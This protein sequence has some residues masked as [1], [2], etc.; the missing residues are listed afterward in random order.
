MNR[1]LCT[2]LILITF[3]PYSASQVATGVA[4]FNS[5]GGG[6]F[7]A[8]NLGNLNVHFSI[9]V[10]HKAGR[11]TPFAYD[12]NYD[13]STYRPVVSNGTTQWQPV[14]SIGNIASYWGWQ[15]LG[16]VFSPYVTY[17]M[18]F[19]SGMCG[20]FGNQPW[21]EYSYSNFTY[22]DAGG[23]PHPFNAGGVYYNSPG[24]PN[25]P[26][27]GAQPP[28]TVTV[29]AQDGSG[30]LMSYSLG[31]GSASGSIQS[32]D[33]TTISAPWLTSPPTGSS[34]YAGTD[35]NGNKISFSNGTYTD[36]LGQAVLVATGAAPNP[37]NFSYIPP[38]NE[39]S[40]TRVSVT[41]N[42][43]NYT[44]KTNFGALDSGGHAIGEYSSSTAVALVDNVT[45][46]DG[47]QYKFQYEPTPATPSIGACTPLPGTTCTTGRILQITLPTGGAITYAYSG[48]AN[49]IISDGSTAGLTRTL[50][51]PGGQWSY[52]RSQVAGNH[53]QNTVTSPTGDNTV[54]DFMEDSATGNGST[55]SFYETKRQVNQLISGVQTLLLTTL[56]CWN[57]N[58][59][60]TT[61]STVSS[62]ITQRQVTLQ[63][64]SGGLQSKT[65]TNYNGSGLVTENDEY[66]YSSGA[67]TTLARKTLISYASL[68]NNIVD[69]PSSVIVYDGGSH[70]LSQTAY[71]YD[72]YTTYPLQSTT[73]TPQHNSI[74]G[75]RGN[76]TTLAST[77]IGATTLTRHFAYYDTG[78]VY[79]DYDV[80]G[81]ITTYNYDATV[82]GNSTRSCGNSFPTSVTL[83]ISG[84]SSLAS[85]TYDCIGGVSTAGTD[86]NGNSRSTS[87]TDTFFWRPASATAPYT[88]TGTTTKNFTYTAYNATNGNLAKV[89]SKMLFNSNN[90][91]VD[92][93]TT[94]SL[95]GQLLYSQ[96]GE[97]PSSANYDST[98][99]LYDSFLRAYKSSMPCVYTSTIFTAQNQACPSAATTTST[100]DGLGRVTQTQDGG[101]GYVTSTYNQNDVKQALGPAPAGENLKQKQLEYDALSRLTS[102]CEI[103]QLASP[104]TCGQIGNYTG[105]LTTYAYGVN[106][107]NYPTMTVTQGPSGSQQTRVYT[108]DLLGR[109]ISEQNPE[110]GTTTYTYDSDSSGVCSGTYTGDLVKLVDAKGNKVCYQYDAIHRKTGITYPSSGPDAS[111]TQSKTFVYDAAAFNGT[112][113]AN[114]KGLMVEAYTGASGSKT[115]DEF[116]SYSVRGELLDTWECTP[117]SG[118][119]G[120]AAPTN[121]YHVNAGFWENGAWKSLSSSFSGLPT[122]TYGIDSMGRSNTVS[123]S[124]GQNPVTSTAYDLA[125][126]KTTVTYG[127]ADSDVVTFD[128]NTGRM[129]QYKFNVASQNVTGNFTWNPNGSLATLAITNQLNSL[130]TQTCAY[131]HDDV[132]R[133]SSVGCLN[134]STHRWD[135]TFTYDAFGNITKTVPNGGTGLSFQPTYQSSTNRITALSGCT[136][137]TDANGQ[138]TY[139]CTHN[140]T[141]DAEHKLHSADANPSNC[142][143]GGECLTYDALGRMVEKAVGSTYTQ[144]VYGPQG[145][146]ATMNGQTL[147]G[148]LIPVPG[149]QVMYTSASLNTTN[150]I[151]YYR[152]AD[153]LGSSRLAATPS[154]TLY[155][156]TAYAPFGEAYSQSGTTDLSFTGQ[157]QDTVSGIYDFSARNDPVNQGRW[158]VPDP[159]GFAAADPAIPQSWNRYA[160]VINNPLVL[161]DPTG[162]DYCGGSSAPYTTGGGGTG[163]LPQP[164]CLIATGVYDASWVDPNYSEGATPGSPGYF[165]NQTWQSIDSWLSQPGETGSPEYTPLPTGGLNGFSSDIGGPGDIGVLGSQEA[166]IPS[167]YFDEIYAGDV[168][169]TLLDMG[170]QI[171][172]SKQCIDPPGA[173]LTDCTGIVQ[174]N[175]WTD[176]RDSGISYQSPGFPS[177]APPGSTAVHPSK[178][179]ELSQAVTQFENTGQIPPPS[180]VK[181]MKKACGIP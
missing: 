140:Y 70:V 129:T 90:S 36:T 20:Q 166:K 44:V 167:W 94:L 138:M 43:V 178:C 122:Q 117:H 86:L 76:S 95:F 106:A 12:L 120:C 109:L 73:G 80:N 15:G 175:H 63:Y 105:Y 5:Y 102:V 75:S 27:S 139:D 119:N 35:R 162:M 29:T 147:I 181:A 9:P 173:Q 91:V 66:A 96:Q 169:Q 26:P 126:F 85:T 158:I 3:V 7:D 151:A 19:N 113:M 177:T 123:A 163:N 135:Q 134:G 143:T 125:N 60:C 156:S 100:F 14:T 6:P 130:D 97:G 77:V 65:V 74:S 144:I 61:S 84:L 110:N 98:Q 58:S 146:F 153:H 133:I 150:K 108:Y 50:S 64:P 104:N 38:A 30:Y 59:S 47:T 116:F 136:P 137:T 171:H 31:S 37:V 180:L 33:G 79:K 155:S 40:G 32:K 154:G 4:P 111:V 41:A 131:T 148:A 159:A 121:Y 10:F 107:S 87:Y 99:V 18:T 45:L 114:P 92:Q 54:L 161:I 8:V 13:S 25:C 48:G 11:G 93:F 82:Q 49:G 128:P 67:P 142:S 68:T 28:G 172:S 179:S 164:S 34:P 42:F 51:S 89:E 88:P 149:S 103:T 112:T 46:P 71:T 145:R 115:T 39:N 165:N 176:F 127:S 168:S 157:E 160:Y 17:K 132:S 118:T 81:Q 1:T 23:T 78:N 174:E 124:A 83:P 170:Y 62:P 152:H 52:A 56:T 57:G 53:W 21:S 69:R 2:L 141:W 72:E 16:P 55:Y 22:Y 24:P 101:T